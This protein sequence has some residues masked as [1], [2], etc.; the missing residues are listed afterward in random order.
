VSEGGQNGR[1]GIADNKASAEN[2]LNEVQWLSLG[3]N[4]VS[5]EVVV[6]LSGR[7]GQ[8][9]EL[10]LMNLQGQPVQQRTVVL[11]AVQQYEVLNVEKAAEGLY[12]LK[13][14]KDNQVK[15]LKVVKRQ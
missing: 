1:E 6:R 11:N 2:E 3:Q 9:I 8:S 13:A 15:T 14:V 4:P 7:I 12:L 10:S 5:T